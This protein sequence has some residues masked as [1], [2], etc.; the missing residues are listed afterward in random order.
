M[1]LQRLVM[2][3]NIV[4]ERRMKRGKSTRGDFL[5]KKGHLAKEIDDVSA[6]TRTTR[7]GV[8]LIPLEA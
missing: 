4:N 5:D 3:F 1:S 7:S 8:L 6:T 2:P